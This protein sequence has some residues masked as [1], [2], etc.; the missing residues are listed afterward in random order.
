MGIIGAGSIGSKAESVRQ[1]INK[2]N[3]TMTNCAANEPDNKMQDTQIESVLLRI[4]NNISLLID[5]LDRMGAVYFDR[6]C[7][8]GMGLPTIVK[9]ALGWIKSSTETCCATF[10][11]VNKSPELGERISLVNGRLL[12]ATSEAFDVYSG[13]KS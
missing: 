3:K 4:E 12:A 8:M 7:E 6:F 11:R 1:A 10:E 13:I 2:L 9:T 5:V